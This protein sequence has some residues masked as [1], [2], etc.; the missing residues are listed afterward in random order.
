MN[1]MNLSTTKLGALALCGTV[2]FTAALAQEPAP[3]EK[4]TLK[5]A[6][7][8]AVKNSRELAVARLQQTL[9]EQAAT[10][11]R[12]EFRP[13]LYAGSGAG[14][15]YGIPQTPGGSAPSIFNVAYI[16]TLLNPPLHGQ[17][18]AAEERAGAQRFAVEQA[19]DAVILRT[20]S[21][22]LELAKVRHSLELLRRER[23][24]A[25]KIVDVT[26]ERA[27]AGFEL[28]IEVTRAQLARA[29][30]EQ[31]ILRLEGREETLEGELH[32][33]TG[34]PA[35]QRIE[36]EVEELP[37]A[38]EHSIAELVELAAANNP[39]LKLAEAE[40]RAREQRLKGE[41]GGNFPTLDLVGQYSLLSRINNFD[42]FF[43][44]FQRHNLNV[45]VQVRFPLFSARTSSAVAL[46]RT[47]LNAAELELK[48]KRSD[49]EIEVRREARRARELDAAR[50][51]A[52]LELQLAQ[53]SL[54]V[55]QAQFQ[56]GRA[57]LRDLE[58]AR[59]QES[60][61]WMGFLETDYNRQQAQLELLRTTGQ[62]ARAFQ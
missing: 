23:E 8:L 7:A 49:L 17:L 1:R 6:V 45:G 20:A 50:E 30:V 15:T 36:V 44:R 42:E 28:S 16:Q 33:L 41:R 12:A 10:V 55:L 53:E 21:A 27:A 9:A 43:R 2:W 19:R 57:S 35:D 39:E 51:V 54:R 62:L 31:H 59:L 52:R 48:N 11:Q 60:E 14:Y 22:Y 61:K 29:Q 47:D 18:R 32:K 13:N 3:A 25:Q 26:G 4:L 46:A 56:E 40:R 24:S 58:K 37:A 5:Q 34:T 38:P